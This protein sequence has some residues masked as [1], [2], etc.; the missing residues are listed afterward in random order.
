MQTGIHAIKLIVHPLFTFFKMFFFRFGFMDS[1]HGLTLAVLYSYHT[2]L[3]Y[4]K[5][6]ELSN[7]QTTKSKCENIICRTTSD[8]Q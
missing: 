5:L 1:T 2:F 3:K 7:K 4:L 6:W 8:G